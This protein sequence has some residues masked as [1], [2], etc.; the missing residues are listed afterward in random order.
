MKKKSSLS[1]DDRAIWKAATA[2]IEPHKKTAAHRRKRLRPIVDEFGNDEAGGIA[3]G[4]IPKP[5]AQ[6]KYQKKWK[7]IEVAP[8]L[9]PFATSSAS[10][11]PLINDL[12]AMATDVF[13]RIQSGKRKIDA[14]LDLHGMTQATAHRRVI[15]FIQSCV[16]GKLKTILIITGKGSASNSQ[17]VLQKN[18][19]R[20]LAAHSE[21]A[22]SIAGIQSAPRDLGGS[23]AFVIT[24]KWPQSRS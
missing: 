5:S 20:W 7:R 1:D 22:R 3:S 12:P 19:P 8:A 24:L 15:A 18:L 6:K 13:G 23:G 14:R 9:K 17:A 21:I 4:H 10:P 11:A 16:S 2:H